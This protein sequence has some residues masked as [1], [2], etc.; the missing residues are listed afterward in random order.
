M[1]KL[2]KIQLVLCT[3]AMMLMGVSQ[4]AL[5]FDASRYA[6]QS[7]LSTGKWVKISIPETGVYELTDAELMEMG[8]SNPSNV[9]LYGYGGYRINEILNG[10]TIDDLRLV[11]VARYP[12]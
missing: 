2:T 3:A 9:R 11:P 4:Q 12:G 5:A 6:T 1:R 7:K 10:R 8:F